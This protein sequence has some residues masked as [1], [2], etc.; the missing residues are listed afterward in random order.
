MNKNIIGN[1]I[2]AD[3]EKIIEMYDY[4]G[5]DILNIAEEYNILPGTMCKKL[6]DWGIKI[7]KGDYHRKVKTYKHEKIKIS[8]ELQ[9]KRD[10][11]TKV[12]N[13]KIKH[14]N[15]KNTTEDQKLVENIIKH[16]IIG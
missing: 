5:I 1:R 11:N 3:K 14:I 16:P 6:H 4:Y 12:N 10:Y 9:A 2:K 8:K 13:E 7:R 15:F